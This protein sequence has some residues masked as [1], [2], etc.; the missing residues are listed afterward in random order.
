M[1]RQPEHH[2]SPRPSEHQ[3]PLFLSGGLSGGGAC[4][5][6]MRLVDWSKNPLGPPETWPTC[7]KITLGTLLHSRHPMFLFWGPEL[8]CFYNDAYL[9]SFGEG[10]HPAAMGQRAEECWREI[11][12]IIGP[13]IHD[14]MSEARPSWNVDHLV[15]IFRNG[16]IE[17]VYW[18]YSNSPVFTEQGSVGGTVVVC[19]ETTSRVLSERRLGTLRALTEKTMAAD[20]PRAIV[21]A[22]AEAFGKNSQDIPFA[23]IYLVDPRSGDAGLVAS[24]GAGAGEALGPST[25]PLGSG[26]ELASLVKRALGPEG[27]VH[28]ANASSVLP[29]LPRG[30][31][32]EP[33]TEAYILPIAS[34]AREPASGV[35]LFGIS[36]RLP[37]DESYRSFFDQ[38]AAQIALSLMAKRSRVQ[39]EVARQELHDFFMQAPAPMCIFNGPDHVFT[40]ANH[41]YV[42][43]VGRDVLGKGVREIFSDDEAGAFFDLLDTVYSTGKSHIGKE[44]PF[45]RPGL[46]GKM[47]DHL[48]NI[49]YTPF[50]AGDGRITGILAFVHDV[51]EQ[52]LAM[53]KADTLAQDLQAAVAARDTFL[54]IASHELKTPLTS[55]MLQAQMNQRTFL[56][57]GSGAFTPERIQKLLENVNRQTERLTRLVDDMLDISRISSGKLAMNPE[58]IDISRLARET[59]ERFSQQLAAAGCDL[60]LDLEPS[61]EGNWDPHR[62]EQVIINLITNV[63]RYAPG[64]PVH[65][66]LKKDGQKAVFAVQDHG[67]GIA[68]E[69]RE[70]V[71]ERFERVGASA[72]VTG[73]GLGLHISRQIV[74]AHG[75]EIHA[76]GELGKGSMF[77]V[78]IPLFP[79]RF[80]A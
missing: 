50:R 6:Q 69:S 45:R 62:I 72:N 37:F 19:S 40:L 30:P 22:A 32:P 1:A 13:Q 74:E 10:K 31:W 80:S 26:G 7:L 75:G 77:V 64:A 66:S 9:P 54:G 38:L 25:I 16:R 41:A 12:P 11:W 76:E 71:F 33:I 53:R 70:R 17:E 27:P 48:L 58:R 55:L 2:T 46:D 29:N 21:Q 59:I 34:E 60:T 20:E 73:L 52:V 44:L 42:E 8:I 79:P 4:G 36:S 18:T 35:I 61:V 56:R 63:I 24:V 14:V 15:P 68:S 67:P 28:V 47:Q 23:R 3:H 49:S 5:A 43:L 78:E 39:A 51:T 57:H 65:A